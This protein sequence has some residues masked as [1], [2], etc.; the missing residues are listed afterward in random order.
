MRAALVF[1]LS[2]F[3]WVATGV[4]QEVANPALGVDSAEPSSGAQPVQAPV[5]GYATSAPAS[6]ARG[7]GIPGRSYSSPPVQ[8][9]A[10]LG[11]PGAATLGTP[12]PIPGAFA[13]IQF[14]PGQNYAL[15][16]RP[17]GDVASI[18]FAG[19]QAG[20]L[21]PLPG[22]IANPDIVAFSPGAAAAAIF[23]S[24]QQRVVIIGGLPDSPRLSGSLSA[25]DLPESIRRLAIADDGATLMA[26]AGDGRVLVLRAG[27]APAQVY[28]S[29]NPLALAFA[30]ASTDALLVDGNALVQIQNAARAPV[31]RI[32]AQG[33]RGLSGTALL[34]FGA[35][36]A[37]VGSVGSKTVSFIDLAS[38]RVDQI[39]LPVGL[40]ALQ[41]LRAAR[42]FLV[43]SEAGKPAWI[44][45]A[46]GEA[47]TV[48]FVPLPLAAGAAGGGR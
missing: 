4:S 43:A 20:P 2:V 18:Q 22:G 19:A 10:M 36:A 9:R 44:L 21:V 11:V 1:L 15:V 39:S 13:S 12:I 34:Q 24:S 23:S 8:V 26:A 37:I 7:R 47:A 45:D 31:A 30:P 35:G 41:P 32:L 42:R 28:N 48:Y 33:L 46:T 3:T 16:E 6:A 27:S 29:T 25:S 17:T 14:A 5:L 40:S 38:F